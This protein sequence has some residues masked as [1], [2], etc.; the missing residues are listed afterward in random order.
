MK[1]ASGYVTA[2]GTFYESATQAEYHEALSELRDKLD[3][4][5]IDQR[6]ID[7]AK[8]INV[9]EQVIPQVERYINAYKKGRGK[10]KAGESHTGHAPAT[11]PNARPNRKSRIDDSARSIIGAI[12]DDEGQGKDAAVQPQSADRGEPMPDVGS[13]K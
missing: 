2:D 8:F 10:P 6:L 11:H 3:S 7:P 5:K 1:K 13:R 4:T 12:L 9:L